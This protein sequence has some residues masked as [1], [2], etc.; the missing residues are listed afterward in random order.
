M[1]T[2]RRGP[3]NARYCVYHSHP[4]R[5]GRKFHLTQI[6]CHNTRSAA[7]KANARAVAKGKNSFVH[8]DREGFLDDVASIRKRRR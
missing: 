1:A 5:G 6:S 8:L 2:R 4:A 3:E 7:E